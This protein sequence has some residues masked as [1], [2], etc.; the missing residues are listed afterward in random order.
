MVHEITW[1]ERGFL[2]EKK[3]HEGKCSKDI[4]RY[5]PSKAWDAIDGTEADDTG[6][7]IFLA[8]G[9]RA[10]DHFEDCRVI[11]EYTI[12]ELKEAI[13]TIEYRDE[14]RIAE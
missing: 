9:Y 12:S 1:E 6:Y 14:W 8:S 7:W 10:Y 11:H 5:I 2:F 4:D 13:K 3:F